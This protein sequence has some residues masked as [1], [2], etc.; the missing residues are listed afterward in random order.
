MNSSKT[1]TRWVGRRKEYK[2]HTSLFEQNSQP[3]YIQFILYRDREGPSEGKED[4]VL[5]SITII[6]KEPNLYTLLQ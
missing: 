3:D 6:D 5:I 1:P 2:N 4:R